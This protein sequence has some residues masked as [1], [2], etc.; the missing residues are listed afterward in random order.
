MVLDETI[1]PE[2]PVSVEIQMSG[3]SQMY[4]FGE[5]IQL[6]DVSGAISQQEYLEQMM[7]DMEIQG[8][9]E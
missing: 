5:D 8:E 1:S 9:N 7:K 6:P 4:G 2:G 3:D